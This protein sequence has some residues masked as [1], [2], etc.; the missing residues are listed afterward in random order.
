MEQRFEA[1]VSPGI[2]FVDQRH[3]KT[4][5]DNG[6][7]DFTMLSAPLVGPARKGMP[8]RFGGKRLLI[9]KVVVRGGNI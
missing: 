2:N 4:R 3:V 9:G 1:V 5:R 7:H 8:P 6:F